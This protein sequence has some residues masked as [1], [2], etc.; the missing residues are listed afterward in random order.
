MSSPLQVF[1]FL[2]SPGNICVVLSPDI[3]M[4]NYS[5]SATVNFGKTWCSLRLERIQLN[6]IAVLQTMADL[7]VD[8]EYT[9]ST[10]SC[11]ERSR[12]DSLQ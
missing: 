12:I 5:C 3:I 9:I 10:V 6:L 7:N 2:D 4:N 8:L 1:I 11:F